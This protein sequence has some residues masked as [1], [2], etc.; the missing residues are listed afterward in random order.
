MS[1]YASQSRPLASRWLECACL[2]RSLGQFRYE[3]RHD[4]GSVW[5]VIALF[6]TAAL[7]IR[8]VAGYF[9]LI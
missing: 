1:S 3:L 6:S 2:R 5:L 9:G 4:L 7:G 8:I